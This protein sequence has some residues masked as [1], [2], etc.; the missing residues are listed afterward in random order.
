MIVRQIPGDAIA[1]LWCSF[2]AKDLS[3]DPWTV[4][5]RILRFFLNFVAA[6]SISL[7]LRG[8]H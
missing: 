2:A 6:E 4:V 5:Y 8:A 3:A 7:S 1:N